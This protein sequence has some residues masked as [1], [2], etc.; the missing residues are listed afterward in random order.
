MPR[1]YEAGVIITF[2]PGKDAAEC[3]QMTVQCVHCGGHYVPEHGS[4]KIRGYCMNCGGYVC[5]PGCEKCVPVEQLLENYEKGREEGF[6]P[7]TIAVPTS[8]GEWL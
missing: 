8:W 3:E 1:K 2:D 5:G 6:R 4:R 7:T